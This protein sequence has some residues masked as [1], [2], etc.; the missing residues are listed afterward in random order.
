MAVTKIGITRSVASLLA[1]AE[2]VE[3]EGTLNEDATVERW[4]ELVRAELA[5]QFPE[6]DVQVRTRRATAAGL[7]VTVQASGEE[8][9]RT[10]RE[11][12]SRIV[13]RLA[14]DE[15]WIVPEVGG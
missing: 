1:R 3:D 4:G 12:V 11:T 2:E 15:D 5:E 9:E 13:E 8:E 6:A 7:D 10:A 14:K